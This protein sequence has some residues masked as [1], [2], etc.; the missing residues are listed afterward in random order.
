M[1]P[2]VTSGPG[3]ANLTT[4][5][6]TPTLFPEHYHFKWDRFHTK[7]LDSKRTIHYIFMN[8]TNMHVCTGCVRES[9]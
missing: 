2:L 5:Q 4:R 3:G 1:G 7:S 6:H 8:S 9:C